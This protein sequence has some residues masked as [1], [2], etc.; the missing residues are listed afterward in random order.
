MIDPTDGVAMQSYTFT[1]T[2]GPPDGITL[3]TACPTPFVSPDDVGI[4]LPTFLWVTPFELAETRRAS[5]NTPVFL[6]A[7][8]EG[9]FQIFNSGGLS[10]VYAWQFLVG[11]GASVLLGSTDVESF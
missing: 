10:G 11:D 8:G 9:T 1:V 6:D 7:N 4:Q 2:G 5:A 3:A